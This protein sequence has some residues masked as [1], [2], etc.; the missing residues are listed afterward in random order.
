MWCASLR[1]HGVIVK[2][3]VIGRS[4]SVGV[5][6]AIN[7]CVVKIVC[8]LRQIQRKILDGNYRATRHILNDS[9]PDDGCKLADALNALLYGELTDILNNDEDGQRYEITGPTLEGYAM[10]VVCRFSFDG[11]R[12]ILITSYVL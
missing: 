12:V 4:W 5:G 1:G 2:A 9:L 10:C 3:N 6:S 11:A 7:G 8:M